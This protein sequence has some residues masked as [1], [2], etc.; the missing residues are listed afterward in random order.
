MLHKGKYSH[1]VSIYEGGQLFYLGDAQTN[2]CIR[3]GGFPGDLEPDIKSPP[4]KCLKLDKYFTLWLKPAL[5]LANS[6][7][8]FFWE[9]SETEQKVGGMGS[10]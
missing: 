5:L 4:Y 6:D 10:K 3:S 8:H 9:P 2:Q 7:R 1:Y